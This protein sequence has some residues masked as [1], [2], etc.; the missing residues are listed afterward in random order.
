LYA[1]CGDGSHF[2]IERGEVEL[3]G[4]QRFIAAHTDWSIRAR[5]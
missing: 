3:E 4:L 1:V 5:A 2:L